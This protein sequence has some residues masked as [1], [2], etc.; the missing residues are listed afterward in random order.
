MRTTN[1]VFVLAGTLILALI[2]AKV[3]AP[4]KTENTP[5]GIINLELA[6]NG[7]YAS[8]IR[9]DW[10]YSF[11]GSM[12]KVAI[13]I[14]HTWLDFVF[15][16]FYSYFLFYG[17]KSVSDSLSG[18]VSKMGRWIAVGALY[19]GLFDIIE[20]IGILL[21]MKGYITNGIA[22]AT[23]IFSAVKWVI[24]VVALGYVALAG[25]ISILRK[26]REG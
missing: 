8:A 24:V 6:F 1:A 5:L 15:I 21:M 18:F 2:M 4:L 3:G 19:A 10:L 12:S 9:L 25:P 7:K 23:G 13:A 20:N 17:C 22:L 16:F 11:S 14:R 26:K